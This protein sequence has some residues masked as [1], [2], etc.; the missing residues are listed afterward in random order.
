MS[1]EEIS[2]KNLGKFI[3]KQKKK[4][5]HEKKRSI[6]DVWEFPVENPS[7]IEVKNVFAEV[8]GLGVKFV[9]QASLRHTWW[10]QVAASP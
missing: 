2:D 10:L 8:I 7:E 1:N 6:D 3:P 4:L 9:M 5:K